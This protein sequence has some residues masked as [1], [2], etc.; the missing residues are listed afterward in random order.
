MVFLYILIGL[1][2]L[3]FIIKI[4][5]TSS[6][7]SFVSGGIAALQQKETSLETFS[8]NIKDT[9]LAVAKLNAKKQELAQKTLEQKSME[10][11]LSASEEDNKT[12]RNMLG[13]LRQAPQVLIPAEIIAR[14]AENWFNY[15]TLNQGTSSGVR[16]GQAVIN[17][18]GVVGKIVEVG[19]NYSKVLTITAPQHKV[20][21]YIKHSGTQGIA[22][23][24]L[25][26]PL[27][28]NYVENNADI[29]AD[30]LVL[31]SGISTTFPKG[32]LIGTVKTA[33]KSKYQVFQEVSV[34]PAVNF[35]NLHYVFI[36]KEKKEQTSW[37]EKK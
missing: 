32:L 20:N 25:H 36:L 35:F 33:R 6:L 28:M 23:G 29:V 16:L 8:I 15:L 5:P 31:T 10:Q 14:S 21:V 26:H 24:R 9:F 37:L 1:F 2:V 22:Q 18:A 27:I 19:K 30:D 17:E 7:P 3:G 34:I 11:L 4:L 13:F 12:L